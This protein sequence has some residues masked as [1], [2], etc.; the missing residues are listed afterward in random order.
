MTD[1]DDHDLHVLRVARALALLER[2]APLLPVQ[3][4][5]ELRTVAPDLAPYWAQAER[6]VAVQEILSRPPDG[7]EGLRIEDLNADNDG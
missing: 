3:L 7:G 6:F 1:V 2:E 4:P 5:D